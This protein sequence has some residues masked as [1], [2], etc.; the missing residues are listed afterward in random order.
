MLP[1]LTGQLLCN[2]IPNATYTFSLCLFMSSTRSLLPSF[3][4]FRAKVFRAKILVSASTSLIWYI[5]PFTLRGQS[6][7]LML[8]LHRLVYLIAEF[9][10]HFVPL[11]GILYQFLK[12]LFQPYVSL[13]STYGVVDFLFQLIIIIFKFRGSISIIIEIRNSA[14]CRCRLTICK[15]IVAMIQQLVWI[16]CY[17][18]L[19]STLV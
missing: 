1:T 13:Q 16:S 3:C 6:Q 19:R 12:H 15:H 18:N 7:A 9:P 10:M 4:I 11:F 14:V 5:H 2:R 17:L 8:L